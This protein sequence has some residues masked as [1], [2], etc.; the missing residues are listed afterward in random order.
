MAFRAHVN[1]PVLSLHFKVFDHIAS[2]VGVGF[3]GFGVCFG[4]DLSV[5]F[6]G[7]FGFCHT[8]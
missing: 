4:F 2:I 1:N 8:R 3:L 6:L 7:L 5:Y